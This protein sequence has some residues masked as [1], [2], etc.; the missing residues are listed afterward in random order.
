M[1]IPIYGPN[2]PVSGFRLVDSQASYGIGLQTSVLG[3][4]VH[5]DW[6]WKT[7]FNRNYEDVLF[8][9]PASQ[10]GSNVRGSDIYRHVKFQFWIGYDF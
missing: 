4:P 1:P 10:V 9:Y 8:Y 5:F 7:R 2:I 3:F 6:A